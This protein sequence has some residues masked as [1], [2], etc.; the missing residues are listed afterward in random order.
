MITT[1]TRGRVS[2]RRTLHEACVIADSESCDEGRR[3]C[4]ELTPLVT[5]PGSL[6]RA[7]GESGGEDFSDMATPFMAQDVMRVQ[8]KRVTV[9]RLAALRYRV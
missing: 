6:R 7:E 2:S 1:Q 9:V 4:L 5:G 8:V 3:E